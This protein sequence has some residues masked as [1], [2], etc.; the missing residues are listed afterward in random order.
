MA[1][2]VC[3]GGRGAGHERY[4]GRHT[5]TLLPACTTRAPLLQ[6]AAGRMDF[7]IVRPGGLKS[8]PPTGR[9]VVTEDRGVCGSITRADVAQL[10][11]QALLRCRGGGGGGRAAG[12][13][14]QPVL[15]GGGPSD[16]AGRRPPPLPRSDVANG[17]VLAA[18]DAEQ[19]F[20]EPQF[21]VV[22]L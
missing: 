5:A 7:V 4:E 17:K 8:E 14:G 6:A 12:T 11:V 3:V 15:R 20:G 16:G 2:G 9:G 1:V 10:T 22:A 13:G 21:E 18:V 19:V